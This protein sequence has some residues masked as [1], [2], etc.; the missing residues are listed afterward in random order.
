[1]KGL[2]PKLKG[3]AGAAPADV[4]A[5]V[6]GGTRN[7]P[8]EGVIRLALVKPGELLA[9]PQLPAPALTVV[10]GAPNRDSDG[11]AEAALVEAGCDGRL[12]TGGEK[13]GGPAA[14][15]EAPAA[16]ESMQ[17]FSRLRQG[18]AWHEKRQEMHSMLT[19]AAPPMWAS[20][21]SH[22][23]SEY[24]AVFYVLLPRGIV[25]VVSAM[26]LLRGPSKAVPA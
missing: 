7:R 13:L 14:A 21:W 18:P 11:R 22:P 17:T 16:G 4:E 20:H 19:I 2:A 12:L 23:H 24:L 25:L 9:F 26:S 5:A 15:P 10:C 1:M 8:L 3:F 6:L